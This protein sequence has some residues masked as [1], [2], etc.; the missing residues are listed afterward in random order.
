MR[1]GIRFTT[2]RYWQK[3]AH[4]L[5]LYNGILFTGC[6]RAANL[7]EMGSRQI[8][9]DAIAAAFVRRTP[10]GMRALLLGTK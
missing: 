9:H 3:M 4:D 10:E 7:A 8:G 5:N 1:Y 2:I 6:L